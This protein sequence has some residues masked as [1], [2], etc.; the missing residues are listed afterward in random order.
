M[1]SLPPLPAGHPR[2]PMCSAYA[3]HMHLMDDLREAGT[4][5]HAGGSVRVAVSVPPVIRRARET[6]LTLTSFVRPCAVCDEFTEASHFRTGI[7][8]EACD[9]VVCEQCA[10]H[11]F[12]FVCPSCSNDFQRVRGG[13]PT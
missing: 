8:C 7:I 3:T 4:I 9:L 10:R 11:C 6:R 2:T 5:V 1:T 13:R 12:E